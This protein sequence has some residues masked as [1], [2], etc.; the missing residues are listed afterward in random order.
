MPS[1]VGSLD[2]NTASLVHIKGNST[3]APTFEIIHVSLKD[4]PGFDTVS[5]EWKDP[6]K[7]H[8][9]KVDGSFFLPVTSSITLALPRLIGVCRTGFLWIDQLCIDQTN[10]AERNQQVRIMGQIYAQSH[11]CHIWISSDEA[12]GERLKIALKSIS[13]LVEVVKDVG[14][15]PVVRHLADETG[16]WKIICW[17]L[18]Q[19]WFERTWVFQE[20]A[21]SRISVLHIGSFELDLDQCG[22]AS[23]WFLVWF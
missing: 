12:Q 11:I 17:L 13:E 1:S 16:A 15:A 10:I 4:S 3:S 5:Y 22:M 2:G 9:I 7:T 8:Q 18:Q 6:T 20:A 19:G 14:Y 21:L 23:A